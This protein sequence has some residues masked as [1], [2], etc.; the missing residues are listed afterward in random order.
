MQEYTFRGVSNYSCILFTN[1]WTEKKNNTKHIEYFILPFVYKIG[2][3]LNFNR[4]LNNKRVK[5]HLPLQAETWKMCVS[6]KYGPTIG[7]S[8]FNY[9]KVLSTLP[10][11]E[12]GDL[13]A[14][15]C[16]DNFFYKSH[17]HC[18]TGNLDLIENM[19]KFKETP[20]CNKCKVTH[21]Y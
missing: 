21:L 19:P 20:R 5:S 13:L 8:I 7:Q 12:D 1:L 9:N 17:G 6:Y 2:D 4:I 3:N 11:N 18:H 16:K 14:C 10:V 15:D